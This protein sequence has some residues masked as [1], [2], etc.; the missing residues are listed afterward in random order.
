LHETLHSEKYL[1][2]SKIIAIKVVAVQTSPISF[3]SH[4]PKKIREVCIQA[5]QLAKAVVESKIKF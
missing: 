4:G 2:M 5:I 1:A 3:A